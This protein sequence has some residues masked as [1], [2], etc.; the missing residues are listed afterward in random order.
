MAIKKPQKL[1]PYKDNQALD[2]DLKQIFDWISRLEVV[3]T[4]P[5]GS[6]KGRYTGEAVILQTGGNTYLEVCN[7]SGTTVWR[8]VQLTDTP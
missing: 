7:G 8:G 1:Y 3:T 6:R 4:N 5:D 2:K